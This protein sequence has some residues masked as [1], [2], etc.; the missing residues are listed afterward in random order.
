MLERLIPIFFFIVGA[1]PFGLMG[2]FVGEIKGTKTYYEKRECYQVVLPDPKV[3][4]PALV[5][6]VDEKIDLLACKKKPPEGGS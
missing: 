4:F 3:V 1:V 5:I 2:A 6:Q